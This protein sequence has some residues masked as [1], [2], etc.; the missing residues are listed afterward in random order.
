MRVR[1]S[2]AFHPECARMVFRVNRRPVPP[3]FPVVAAFSSNARELDF[4]PPTRG[5]WEPPES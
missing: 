2:E 1:V 5:L 4:T 3:M